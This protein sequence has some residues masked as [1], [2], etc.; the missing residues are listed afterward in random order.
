MEDLGQTLDSGNQFIDNLTTTGRFVR[1]DFTIKNVGTDASFV[2]APKIVDATGR[3]FDTKSEGSSF[4]EDDKK[5]I[6]EKINPGLDR[7]CS[8]IYELPADASGLTIAVRDNMFGS[9]QFLATQ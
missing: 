4:L 3:E 9:A 2:D 8:W 1:V 6:L 7:P 5:C